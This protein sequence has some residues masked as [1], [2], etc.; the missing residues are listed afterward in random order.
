MVEIA[1]SNYCFTKNILGQAFL[2]CALL[3]FFM[4]YLKLRNLSKCAFLELFA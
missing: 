2:C 1:V 4:E 3:F